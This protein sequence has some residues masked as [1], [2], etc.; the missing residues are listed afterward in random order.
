M[1]LQPREDLI[2]DIPWRKLDRKVIEQDCGNKA[3]LHVCKRL[4][5][6]DAITNAKG[7]K[8]ALVGNELG[9]GV[10]PFGDELEWPLKSF[11]N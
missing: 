6:A 7:T 4:A 9:L 10:P 5:N 2:L 1:I 11:R 3:K 8:G